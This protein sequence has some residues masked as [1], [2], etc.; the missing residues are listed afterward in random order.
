MPRVTVVMIAAVLLAACATESPAPPAPTA[1]APAAP[2]VAPVAGAHAELAALLDRY[3]EE[4]LE[5]NPLLA[6]FIGDNRYNDRLP[7]DIGP[8]Q[9]ARQHELNER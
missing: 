5:L 9:R 7:N 4:L 2:V 3:F 8:E 1:P 6:T